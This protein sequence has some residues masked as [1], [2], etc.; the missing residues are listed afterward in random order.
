MAL[1]TSTA[2]SPS[3]SPRISKPWWMDKS[4]QSRTGCRVNR[5][6]VLQALR[7]SPRVIFNGCGGER[8]VF[9]ADVLARNVVTM[10]PIGTMKAQMNKTVEQIPSLPLG[11][12]ASNEPP[13]E[14]AKRA[15][16]SGVTP[17]ESGSVAYQRVHGSASANAAIA[18]ED[19]E[20]DEN[21]SVARG[22]E[23]GSRERISR[24][25]YWA[26]CV[27]G[28]GTPRFLYSG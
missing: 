9:N 7:Y 12:V 15:G 22:R 28:E 19:V 3:T 14:P 25:K 16:L 21:G 1:P 17:L 6:G 18:V 23:A 8:F 10:E 5:L 4:A 26:W 27:L 11:G 20:V 24:P 2:T 13:A